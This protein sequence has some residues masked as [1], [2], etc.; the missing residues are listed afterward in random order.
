MYSFFLNL[1]TEAKANLL[2]LV[3]LFIYFILTLL[4][5]FANEGRH[6]FVKGHFNPPKMNEETELKE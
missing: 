5:F 1:S 2:F 4:A 3:L 6:Y